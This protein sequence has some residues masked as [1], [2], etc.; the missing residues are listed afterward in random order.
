M[1]YAQIFTTAT[2]TLTL[3][4]LFHMKQHFY[5][6]YQAAIGKKFAKDICVCFNEIIRN[7]YNE[8]VNSNR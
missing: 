4:T 6:Q 7:K 5:K 8:N 1:Y 3:Y 2:D